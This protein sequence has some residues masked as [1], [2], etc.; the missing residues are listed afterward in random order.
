MLLQNV[1]HK[2]EFEIVCHMRFN[3]SR[4]SGKNYNFL[5]TKT[6]Y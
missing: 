5:R 1:G 4:Q 6:S 2:F 3:D